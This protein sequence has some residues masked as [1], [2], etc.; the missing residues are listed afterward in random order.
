[1]FGITFNAFGDFAFTN[2]D[3]YDLMQVRTQIP[4]SPLDLEEVQRFLGDYVEE[5]QR[6]H[7]E[8]AEYILTLDEAVTKRRDGSMCRP[9]MLT[10]SHLVQRFT[11]SVLVEEDVIIA[12]WGR[13]GG[14]R[15]GPIA[16]LWSQSP[17]VTM[18]KVRVSGV[19]MRFIQRQGAD[20][21]IAVKQQQVLDWLNEGENLTAYQQRLETP[22]REE[23]L[24]F[25]D[26]VSATVAVSLAYETSVTQVVVVTEKPCIAETCALYDEAHVVVYG[27]DMTDTEG[28]GIV[29]KERKFEYRPLPP[30]NVYAD[31]ALI[32][33][34]KYD[35]ESVYAP[36]F[37]SL[38]QVQI[39]LPPPR[40]QIERTV[41]RCVT[42][43]TTVPY[44]VHRPRG[45]LGSCVMCREVESRWPKNFDFSPRQR[46]VWRQLHTR[47]R[48]CEYI[49]SHNAPVAPP[50]FYRLDIMTQKEKK[51]QGNKML[52]PYAADL[53]MSQF[54]DCMKTA[55]YGSK[56]GAVVWQTMY[57][58]DARWVYVFINY[59]H[60]AMILRWQERNR[61]NGLRAFG[62]QVMRYQ[63]WHKR[64]RILQGAGTYRLL[65]E[66]ERIQLRLPFDT[67]WYQ[68]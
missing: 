48:N 61:T 33:T 52:R 53:S 57:E 50:V 8:W 67:S 20:T 51:R 43:R 45:R 2:R 10:P 29:E 54:L 36:T 15:P 19:D 58:Q 60:E 38:E 16:V 32:Y 14:E 64:V 27:A 13:P 66:L 56:V 23:S 22:S 59:P 49:F 18:H 68:Q 25:C 65:Q 55:T 5:K 11:N 40:T 41:V 24:D 28:A 63:I 42:V 47:H 34:T 46:Q 62:D 31:V 1:M 12:Q 39:E 44:R 6:K 4:T 37:E 35:Y 3:P 9:A 26:V 21:M 17:L 7:Q 30:R